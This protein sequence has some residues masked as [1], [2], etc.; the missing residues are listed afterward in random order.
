MISKIKSIFPTEEQE[1]I[2]LVKWLF[3]NKIFFYHVPN[4]SC[5]NIAQAIKFKKLGLRSGVPD[6][7]IPIARKGFHGLYIELKRQKS[8]KCAVSDEQK[9]WIAQ[10]MSEGYFALICRGAEDSIK[11]ITDYFG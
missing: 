1:Q 6:I 2:A 8:V 3:S 10:L 9:W 7:C 4:G 11:V 5:K